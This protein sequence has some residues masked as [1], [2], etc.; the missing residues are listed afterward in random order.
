VAVVVIAVAVVVVLHAIDGA[1]K[2]DF[3]VASL[4]ILPWKSFY[5]KSET[6]QGRRRRLLRWRWTTTS[7]L[8]DEID[9]FGGASH[10]V[11]HAEIHTDRRRQG[12][13]LYDDDDALLFYSP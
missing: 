13:S 12:L 7:I 1:G 11:G 2:E 6:T 10:S 5:V 3:R 4:P 9:V 8:S